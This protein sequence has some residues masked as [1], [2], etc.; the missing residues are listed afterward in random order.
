[1]SLVIA[2]GTQL[3]TFSFLF[4]HSTEFKYETDDYI[5]TIQAETDSMDKPNIGPQIV[6]I[7][8]D[9]A[10]YTHQIEVDEYQEDQL[11][12]ETLETPQY[13]NSKSAFKD[14]G[15]V[16]YITAP[17]SNSTN[18][19]TDSHQPQHSSQRQTKMVSNSTITLAN[20]SDERFLLSCLPIMK[21]L[22]TRKNALARLRIQ[23]L[24]YEI[25]FDA[26]S[27]ASGQ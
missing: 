18:T 14:S 26:Y 27:D 23:Q 20:D 13:V 10:E 16:Y 21:R 8:T 5:E 15:S 4:F 1:M 19:A 3:L 22:P 24:L 17:T 2:L 7:N 25:E 11:D 12:E 6:C 9:G